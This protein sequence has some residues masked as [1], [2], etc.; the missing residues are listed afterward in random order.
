MIEK[1]QKLL[2]TGISV[3]GDSYPKPYLENLRQFFS[4]LEEQ[5]LAKKIRPSGFDGLRPPEIPGR[6]D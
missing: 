1:K 2:K 6:Y 4:A 3:F 5:H